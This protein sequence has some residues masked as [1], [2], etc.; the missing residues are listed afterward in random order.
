[1]KRFKNILYFADGAPTPGPALERAV[2]L[3]R[4]NDAR[5][6]VADVIEDQETR[7][8]IQSSFGSDLN[9]ILREHRRLA[10][11][12][13]VRPFNEPDNIIYTQV[14]TGTPFI[15]VIRSVLNNRYDLVV[16]AC[17]APEGVSERLFG[18][19]DMHLMRKCP[20]PVWIDRPAAT[21]PYRRI[22]A[23]VDPVD[24]ESKGCARMVMD[25]ATSLA[26]R[27]SAQLSV[28]HAWSLYGESMLRS[29]RLRLSKTQ[30]E[31]HIDQVRRCHEDGFNRLLADY[32]MSTDDPGVHLVKGSPAATIDRLTRDLEADLVVMGTVG[33]TGVP[34]FFIGNTA[35]EL[36]QTTTTSVLAVKPADF[37]TPV[38]PLRVA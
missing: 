1:M 27:E 19:N 2:A 20:C 35:E 4:T 24:D 11:E 31:Q 18:S 17:R 10:L 5:L 32:E 33:R 34:G 3:A 29:G 9:E 16:K 21:L 38:T 23:A 25:L 14:L 6:T 7:T 36:L 26:K 15:E 8:E 30:F 12:E 13:M 37:K 28:I 22:L